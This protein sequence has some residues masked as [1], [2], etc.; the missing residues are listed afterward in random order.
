MTLDPMTHEFDRGNPVVFV[1]NGH[2]RATSLDVAKYFGKRHADVVRAVRALIAA[3]PG[4]DKRTF[5]FIEYTDDQGRSRP[6][7]NMD[8]DGFTLVAMGFTGRDA[9]HFK[10]A[11]IQAF[12]Q[13]ETQL[14]TTG[15]PPFLTRDFPNWPPNE[16]RVKRGV[17]DLYRM[18]Y[19]PLAAQWIMPQLGF[20]IPPRKL[21]EFGRQLLLDL[22]GS[23]VPTDLPDPGLSH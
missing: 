11:Y 14:N 20:P 8:R 5:A 12:N 19:G 10:W 22:D 4:L 21:V 1:E 15:E 9:L 23:P 18:S 6:L 2:V 3:E 7:V 16:M 17:A 13:M